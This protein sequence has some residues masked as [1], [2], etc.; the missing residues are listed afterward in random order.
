MSE[1]LTGLIERV[2]HH[3]PENGFAVLKVLVKGRHCLAADGRDGDGGEM[4]SI[5]NRRAA[6][7]ARRQKA[8][9]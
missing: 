4:E 8:V 3:N 6:T 1:T 5:E 7:T 9:A 2:T